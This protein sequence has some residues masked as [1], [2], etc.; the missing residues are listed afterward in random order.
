MRGSTH[1]TAG[2][3]TG[4]ALIRVQHIT[5]WRDAALTV[6]VAGLASLAPDWLQISIPGVKIRGAMGHRGFSHW[7]LT[8]LAVWWA[9][10]QLTPT[11]ALAAALGWA[12]HIALDTLNAPGVPALWPLGRVQLARIKSGGTGDEVLMWILSVILIWTVLA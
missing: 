11:L 4:V 3:A 5:G 6:A 10:A 9:V 7:L 12:S 1:L 8:A 2:L